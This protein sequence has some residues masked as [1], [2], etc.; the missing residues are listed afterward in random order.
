M[1][2]IISVPNPVLRQV[3]KTISKLD[4]KTVNFIEDL[5]QTLFKKTDPPGLGISAVQVGKPIR[6]F[7]TLLPK[8]DYTKKGA[9]RKDNLL[10]DYFI[11][12][13]ITNKSKEIT[14]GDDKDKPIL[15]GCLSI[16]HIWAPVWR[17]QTIEVSYQ[18]IKDNKLIETT[19]EFSGF[20]ARVI[21]HEYDHLEGILFTDYYQNESPSS[22]FHNLGEVN[23][24]YFDQDD[25][26]IPIKH[27]EEI[28]TW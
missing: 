23:Q 7:F 24:I 4:K 10:L 11:N 2:K 1:K 8:T 6:V 9:W 19:K 13:V 22:S 18:T 17:H 5:G 25:K 12:P 26:F 14:L 28:L 27:P 15:E 16:P 21:Q 3:S 20:P